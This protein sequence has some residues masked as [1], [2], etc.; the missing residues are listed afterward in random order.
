M[1]RMTPL[2][3]AAAIAFAA[4]A[5]AQQPAAGKTHAAAPSQYTDGEV[6]RIDKEAGKIT[7]KHG[8]IGN[9]DM[10]AMSMVFRA[11]DPKMLDKVKP[12]DKVRFKADNVGG[13]LT[14][15]EIRPAT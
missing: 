13:T 15:I 10:P 12:G 11:A 8:P 5:H 1:N 2:L 3:A 9:L 6:K 14:V 4:C 7:L